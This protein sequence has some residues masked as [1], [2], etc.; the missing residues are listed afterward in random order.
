MEEKEVDVMLENLVARHR[1]KLAGAIFEIHEGAKAYAW[2]K[3]RDVACSQGCSHCC[4]QKIVVTAAEGVTIYRHL[5]EAG[6]WNDELKTKL[7]S[8][9]KKM[10]SYD[11]ETWF[12]RKRPCVFLEE[13]SPGH[14]SCSIYAARPLSCA[15][16][17]SVGFNPDDCAL[18]D[19][20]KSDGLSG[21]LQIA[22]TGM[23]VTDFV[24]SAMVLS[25]YIEHEE[26]PHLMTLPGAVLWAAAAFSK[27]PSPDV[28][29]V[30]YSDEPGKS[31]EDFDSHAVYTTKRAT[32]NLT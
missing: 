6:L 30:E 8:A 19:G 23:A 2:S 13:T 18:V 17:F 24:L 3:S 22:V 14:G 12:E 21:Q 28:L 27:E 29:R 5:L 11:H 31:V 32:G 16:T 15:A 7:A 26:E 1:E 10:T 4:Y 9:D 20:V 25:M